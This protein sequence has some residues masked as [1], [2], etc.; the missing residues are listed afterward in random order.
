MLVVKLPQERPAYAPGYGV[1]KHRAGDIWLVGGASH[2]GGAVIRA[3][4]GDGRLHNRTVRLAPNRPPGFDYYPL[5]KPGEHFPISDFTYP[6]RLEPRPADDAVFCQAILAG[7]TWIE[8]LAYERFAELSAP[9]L[10][11]VRSVGGGVRDASWA[12]MRQKA[13]GVLFLPA[14]SVEAAVGTGSLVLNT[15]GEA[16]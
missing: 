4:V 14:R 12:D 6:P 16:R 15:K 9:Q 2:S 10:A 13:L 1:Y 8:Q 5:L 7:T 3:L 11:S